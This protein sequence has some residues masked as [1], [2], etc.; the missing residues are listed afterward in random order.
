MCIGTNGGKLFGIK[1]GMKIY[2]K[3]HCI[4]YVPCFQSAERL[5][6]RAAGVATPT[7]FTASKDF[8]CEVN[9]K[10]CKHWLKDNALR[11][12]VDKKLYAD[13][14][15]MQRKGYVDFCPCED[16]GC[17]FFERKEGK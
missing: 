2:C 9:C 13:C 5:C 7:S 12:L 10:D 8:S 11:S 1:A 14:L 4:N 17:K 3:D 16:F 15:E 6:F